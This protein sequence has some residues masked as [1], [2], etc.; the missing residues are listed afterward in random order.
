MKKY[1]VQ[2]PYRGIPQGTELVGPLPVIGGGTGFFPSDNLPGPEGGSNC[3]FSSAI[4]S[5]PL[6]FKE[7]TETI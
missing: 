2:E 4:L 5:N 6:I 1:I 7:I 3:I